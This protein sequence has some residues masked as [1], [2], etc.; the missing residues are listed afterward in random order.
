MKL[1]LQCSASCP[2]STEETHLNDNLILISL[3]L[4]QIYLSFSNQFSRMNISQVF[5]NIHIV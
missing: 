3:F 1:P 5:M 2:L 4:K